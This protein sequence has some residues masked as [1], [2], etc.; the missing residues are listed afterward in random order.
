M[1]VNTSVLDGFRTRCCKNT[2]N[3]PALI[4]FRRARDKNNRAIRD[5]FHENSKIKHDFQA[6][7]KGIGFTAPGISGWTVLPVGAEDFAACSFS[8]L[9]SWKCGNGRT[10]IISTQR[11]CEKRTASHDT[12]RHGALGEKVVK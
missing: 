11:M 6:S 4:K 2:A 1:C 10:E 9:L 12:T 8:A 5:S 7:R 3:S